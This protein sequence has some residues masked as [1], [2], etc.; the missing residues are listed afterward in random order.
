MIYD[1]L[2]W[3]RKLVRKIINNWVKLMQSVGN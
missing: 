1:Q 2:I 3:M